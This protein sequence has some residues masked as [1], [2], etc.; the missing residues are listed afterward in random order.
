MRFPKLAG[1]PNRARLADST[2]WIVVIALFL[3]LLLLLVVAG[4]TWRAER[5]VAAVTDRVIHDYAAVAVWQYA[6]RANRA[7]HD[8]VTRTFSPPGIR[9]HEPGRHPMPASAAAILARKDTLR[10]ALLR[11]A[12]VAFIYRTGT[13]EL[14]VAGERDGAR[15]IAR[16]RP[17]LDSLARAVGPG[18]EPHVM[19]F[20]S[21]D[22]RT[23]AI[24]IWIRREPENS[25][26][27][28]RGVVSDATALGPVFARV[29]SQPGLLPGVAGTD[30]LTPLDLSVRLTRGDGSV[31]Y[32]AGAPP[33]ATAAVDSSGLPISELR[34]T[35][36]LPPALAH[37]LVGA[38]RGSQ[39]PALALMIL[40]SA[41]LAGIGLAQH[42]RGRALMR[43]R[44]RFVAN[45]SHELRT[46]LA[47][48]SMFA[49]TLHLGRE[50]SEEERRQ[51][52]GI[53]FAEA[54][55]LTTLVEN[56]LR[57]SRGERAAPAV[58]AHPHDARDL[59]RNAVGT[60]A[61]I[62]AA[63]NVDISADIAP[64]IVVAA[65]AAAFQQIMLNL[66]DNAVKHG[67]GRRV[68][69]NASVHDATARISVDDDGPGV[70]PEWRAR[71]FEPFAQ[72]TGRNVT[73]AGIGLAVVRDLTRA[74]HGEV[75]I[76][77]SPLGGARVVF[78]LPRS[79]K[80]AAPTPD[81]E[82]QRSQRAGV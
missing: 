31:V 53:V 11:A 44:T 61:P 4:M 58:R 77:P 39:L 35:L 50:R 49:E 74:L 38:A 7:L 64:G 67:A 19:L 69:V 23:D 9:E 36:D 43:A 32:A 68:S 41:L 70:P 48:I 28:I 56:V 54:R 45:T 81:R 15:T 3:P 40:V 66:L 5:R 12:R 55:R 10:P 65:D 59:I 2:S 52:A 1:A 21:A 62:A 17:R 73:G 60:F 29:L 22:G 75:W 8:Q 51:F 24:A 63:A 26:P 14:D 18:D 33:G 79:E 72:V 25:P 46:P 47:Q 30:S 71:V 57:F 42:A 78:S 34:A 20:D 6:R 82:P 27:E 13:G 37:K 80:V 76:E 16:L